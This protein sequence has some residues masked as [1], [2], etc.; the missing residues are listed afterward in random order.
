VENFRCIKSADLHLTPLHA[1]IGPN[2]SGKSSILRALHASQGTT[3]WDRA[4]AGWIKGAI[5]ADG[6]VGSIQSVGLGRH[7]AGLDEVASAWPW[8]VELLAPRAVIRLDPDEMRAPVQLIRHGFPLWFHDEKGT[9]L[10]ALYD[11]LLS[12]NIPAFSA[13]YALGELWLSFADGDLERELVPDSPTPV[14]SAG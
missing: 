6:G 3:W 2:D 8:G 14:A 7:S 4:G 9:G 12:R 1:L 11:A 13:I 5:H 10:A